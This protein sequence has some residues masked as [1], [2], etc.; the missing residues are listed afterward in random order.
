MKSSPI[1]QLPIDTM[2][3]ERDSQ[4]VFSEEPEILKIEILMRNWL[5]FVDLHQTLVAHSPCT[6]ECANFTLDTIPT[7]NKNHDNWILPS[8]PLTKKQEPLDEY[9]SNASYII[10]ALKF[11]Q[12]NGE[13]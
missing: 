8:S 9:I 3:N 11:V 12:V 4:F 7:F 1:F 6:R 10:E 13:A 2:F 5:K